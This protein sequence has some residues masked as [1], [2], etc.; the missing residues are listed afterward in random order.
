MGSPSTFGRAAVAAARVLAAKPHRHDLS[1]DQREVLTGWPGWG[2]LAPIFE[3][4]PSKGWAAVGED[5]EALLGAEAVSVGSR[6]CD[7][8]FFTSP[9]VAGHVWRLLAGAGFTGGRVLDLGC[10]HGRF[11]LS[12]PDGLDVEYHG[13]EIDPTSAQV[14]QL[15]N[16]H[17][18]ILCQPLQEVTLPAGGFD[19]AVGN[20]PFGSGWI[21]SRHGS[22]R[23]LH[24]YFLMRA[25]D[26]VRP[27]GLV[28]VITSRYHLD[29]RGGLSTVH[30]KARFVGA[31]RLP[32][33]A[34]AAEGT[35]V[36]ADLVVLQVR[37]LLDPAD[38]PDAD[39]SFEH[40]QSEVTEP[41]RA[42]GNHVYPAHVARYFADRPELVAGQMRVTG[43][44]RNNLAVVTRKPEE[45]IGRA[46]AA[47]ADEMPSYVAR[48]T[49][50]RWAEAEILVDAEGRAEGSFHLVAGEVH[51]VV[52]GELTSARGGA[53]KEL[54]A[55]V[56][57]RD[58]VLEL[59]A[60]ESDW[61]SPDSVLEPLRSEALRLYRDYVDSFGPLNRSTVIDGPLDPE[62][63]QPSRRVRRPRMGGFRADPQAEIVFGIERFDDASGEAAPAAVLLRRTNRRPVLVDR[64]ATPAEAITVSL[65]RRGCLH[66]PTVAGLLG[67]PDS[68]VPAVLGALAFRDPQ[69]GDL[70]PAGD[71]LSG[72]LADKLDAARDAAAFDGAFQ[73]NVDALTEALPARLG[74]EEISVAFGASWL[75]PDDIRHFLTGEMGYR[76]VSVSYTA[77]VAYWD[78]DPLGRGEAAAEATYGTSRMTVAE[79]VAAGLNGGT[80][81]VYDEVWDEQSGK[82]RKVR[83]AG[84]S[85]L[86]ADRLV[87]LTEAFTVWLWSDQSRAERI[88]ETYNRRFNSVVPRQADG[89]WL[90]FPSMSPEVTLWDNQLRGIDHVLRCRSQA[91]MLAHAVGAGKTRAAL[92]LCLKLR[93]YGLANRPLVTVP[94]AVLEQ[95]GR[96]A[97]ATFP[98]GKFLVATEEQVAGRAKRRFVARAAAG[99]WDAIIVSHETFTSLSA[100]PRVEMDYLTE[101]LAALETGEENGAGARGAK[102]LAARRRALEN[103][104]AAL[105]EARHDPDS[106]TFSMLGADHVVVDEAHL[107]KGLPVATRTSG[108]SN[109]TSQRALDLLIKITSL[110]AQR[111][112]QAVATVMSGSP[113]SNSLAEVYTW[114]RMCAPDL[115]DGAG[116]RNFDQWAAT[117]VQWQTVIETSPDGSGLRTNTRPA[118]IRNAPEARTMMRAF[119]DM[120]PSAE[121]PI[122]RPDVQ[123]HLLVAEPSTA[124]VEHMRSLSERVEK[125]RLAGF[126]NEKGG[127]NMLRVCNDGRALALDP[128][129]VGVAARSPKLVLVADRIAAHHHEHADRLY[130]G[131]DVPGTFQ[132]VCLDLGAPHESDARTY[133][134]LRSLLAERGVPASKVRFIQEART[135]KAREE[136]FAACRDGRVSVLVGSSSTAGLG[137]NVQARLSALY[138]VDCPWTPA[139]K[140]QREGR[141]VRPGNLNA[142]VQIVDVVTEG[143]FDGLVTAAV[144]RKHTMIEQMYTNAPMNREVI[145]VSGDAVSLAEVS[146]AATG[147]PELIE[148]AELAAQVQ[149]LRIARSSHSAQAQQMRV[150]AEHRQETARLAEETAAGLDWVARELPHRQR[151]LTR[152]QAAEAAERL[153]PRDS[154]TF[155][156]GELTLAR[157]ENRSRV[158]VRR[159]G[160]LLAR[161][162]L[163]HPVPRTVA[164]FADALYEMVGRWSADLPDQIARLRERAAAERAESARLQEVA[165]T[166]AFPREREL[167]TAQARLAELTA[168]IEQMAAEQSAA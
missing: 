43:H 86:A 48:G 23:N 114:A 154:R 109:S 6:Q 67:I 80:P 42:T 87:A 128:R 21:H 85:E 25:V 34:F 74:P 27:G 64:V 69:T 136:V 28:A 141:A 56:R 66:V 59:L 101:E 65:A 119:T 158:V 70:V 156:F 121:L 18:R 90:E 45:M 8:A 68:E 150:Q 144:A 57:L 155:R 73:R 71:Y 24:D 1:S 3:R 4:E 94:K 13:V 168:R 133:G 127:D 14:A 10:G 84:E 166:M 88:V 149:K 72:N 39:G 107:F 46:F 124:Q 139:A 76:S 96:E 49:D 129:L 5:L 79:I 40:A 161:L 164:G 148:Q 162:E 140:T 122:E 77:A 137:V 135:A 50:L 36:V 33:K 163:P 125:L 126:R 118:R 7:N 16:P 143:T 134:R 98:T 19:V 20:V 123:R 95:F 157:G 130:P 131:S 17:A 145:D 117:F 97:R 113:F 165:D 53:G 105:R 78:V 146:A 106:L 75:S 92:G 112:G 103:R 120:L 15:L 47:L 132:L 147:H 160:M 2:P 58:A 29:G 152:E 110:S 26:A 51:Q 99:D 108:L 102:A 115:L 30:D 138:H 12:C 31:L 44:F 89:S 111:P 93:E 104:V 41:V 61:A 32:S 82:V 63:G 142:Q 9:A 116:C 54:G 52:N 81:V 60:A 11:A 151:T 153:R 83:N 91:A 35:D 100:D 167:L 62:T 22:A 55:L 159:Y 37:D 38:S